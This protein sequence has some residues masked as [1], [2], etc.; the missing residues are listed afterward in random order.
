VHA[1]LLGALLGLLFRLVLAGPADVYARLLAEAPDAVPPPGSLE[2]WRAAPVSAVFIR[3]FVE[4]SWW[5][6][7]LLG[8]I[9]IVRRG[10]IL[11]F[12]WGLIA[13]AAAGVAASGTLACLW[14]WLDWLP[15][16][17]WQQ[18]PPN[19]GWHDSIPWLTSAWV[20]LAALCWMAM[21]AVAGLV[22]NCG[23]R[24]FGSEA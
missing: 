19:F 11:N 18:L 20:A 4:G 5:L 10:G 12:P 17:L 6:G 23:A 7:A 24:V 8:A 3:H 21:G 13:G 16:T 9:L 1:V 14:P 22:L 15:R 2:S